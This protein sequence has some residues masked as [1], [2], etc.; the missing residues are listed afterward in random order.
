MH[1]ST[2]LYLY[3]LS[4]GYKWGGYWV[5]EV[6]AGCLCGHHNSQCIET[7]KKTYSHKKINK[8]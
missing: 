3:I 4:I 8:S 5:L 1:L 2:Y 6:R 7:N